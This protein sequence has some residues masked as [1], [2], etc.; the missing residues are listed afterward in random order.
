MKQNISLFRSLIF[1]LLEIY[2]LKTFYTIRFTST[3]ATNIVYIKFY[4]KLVHSLAVSR[5]P[6]INQIT[7]H[8]NILW[9]EIWIENWGYEN[10][11]IDQFISCDIV[12]WSIFNFMLPDSCP[13]LDQ[14]LLNVPCYDHLNWHMHIY[15]SFLIWIQR[16]C[17]YSLSPRYISICMHIYST[18]KSNWN[19]IF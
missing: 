19:D 18:R 8:S 5:V 10:E 16:Q 7:P 2:F 3:T 14:I 9:S 13:L 17:L 4:N 11:C 15:L 12:F 1:R 6:F